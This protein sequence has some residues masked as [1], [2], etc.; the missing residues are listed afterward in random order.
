MANRGQAPPPA[1]ASPLGAPAVQ[2]RLLGA[3]RAAGAR[4]DLDSAFV[5]QSLAQ[6]ERLFGVYRVGVADGFERVFEAIVGVLARDPAVGQQTQDAV[7][8]QLGRMS[9]LINNSTRDLGQAIAQTTQAIGQGGP[10]A[11]QAPPGGQ[12]GPPPPA[13]VV[14]PPAPVPGPP[15]QPFGADDWSVADLFQGGAKRRTKGRKGRKSRKAQ[16]K[17]T[18]QT[19]HR[20]RR[21]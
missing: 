6:L 12:G 8:E 17:A 15:P 20:K 19:R 16:K 2:Q 21:R 1:P 7:T 10:P 4:G 18:K 9:D 3:I 14:Y 11:G 13:A 5:Q